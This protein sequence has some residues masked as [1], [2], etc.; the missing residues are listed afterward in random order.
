MHSLAQQ[1][2]S[3]MWLRAWFAIVTLTLAGVVV[4]LQVGLSNHYLDRLVR[5]EQQ[6]S[7]PIVVVST[8]GTLLD[9]QPMTPEVE[10]RV[11]ASSVVEA[12]EVRSRSMV[13]LAAG[14]T[15]YPLAALAVDVTG[16]G[17]SAP[18]ALSQASRQLLVTP[19]HVLLT[20]KDAEMT[21]FRL[22]DSFVVAGHRL[23]IVGRI[24]GGFGRNGSLVSQQ[25]RDLLVPAIPRT[26]PLK[27][28]IILVRGQKGQL[29]SET[30]GRLNQVLH[31]FGA[32]AMSREDYVRGLVQEG[33]EQNQDVRAYLY[34]AT[35]VGLIALLI[36]AQ[37]VQSMIAGQR[38]E[39]A[40]LVAIGV[41]RWRIGLIV[42]E[43]AL[44]LGLIAAA[45]AIP[46]ALVGQ[47]VLERFD[48]PIALHLAQ[49]LP[50]SGIILVTA[51]LA[52]LVAI[53]S[54]LTLKPVQLLR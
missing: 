14:P 49:I 32:Q 40:T 36:I 20:D 50:I 16:P 52:G 23:Q 46:T 1:Q 18:R 48:V 45:L 42:L 41:T 43:Q 7:A 11:R 26:E 6:I 10:A 44:W 8:S 3:H 34:L 47:M 53:P 24:K 28:R 39:L 2:L 22:G 27:P 35:A 38:S 4:Y 25:T 33:I 15:G 13:D 51:V 12:F 19:G 17:L 54:V 29:L 9:L 37:S 31:L 21:G 30:L 5:F